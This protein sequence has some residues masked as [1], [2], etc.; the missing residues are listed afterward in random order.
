MRISNKTALVLGIMLAAAITL[1]A[2]GAFDEPLSKVGLNAETCAENLFGNRLCGDELVAFCE[3]RYDPDINEA[4]CREVLADAG[5]DPELVASDNAREQQDQIA[6][7]I[8]D[9]E[10]VERERLAEERRANRHDATIGAAAQDDGVSFTVDRPRT[11][12]SIAAEYDTATPK[13]GRVFL[14]FDVRYTNRGS[15]P[16]ELLCDVTAG[17][18]GFTLID[19]TGRQFQPNADAMLTAAANS[20]ACGEAVQPGDSEDALI[21]FQVRPSLEP[22]DLLVWNPA[23]PGPDEGGSHLDMHV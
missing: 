14:T 20:E 22:R 13:P 18:S 3:E 15:R 6:E 12:T 8:A 17:R 4:T 1:W 5:R 16:I 23:K 21:V 11:L 19:S 9:T 2:R 7:T 10:R